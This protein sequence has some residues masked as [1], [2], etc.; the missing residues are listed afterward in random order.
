MKQN[1]ATVF[2]GHVLRN[3]NLQSAS[4]AVQQNGIANSNSEY[5]QAAPWLLGMSE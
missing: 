4:A 5:Y 3:Q 1:M 2:F